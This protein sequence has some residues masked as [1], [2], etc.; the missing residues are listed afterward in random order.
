[1]NIYLFVYLW[2]LPRPWKGPVQVRGLEDSA[3]LALQK[4]RFPHILDGLV[5]P[6]AC[7]TQFY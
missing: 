7:D 4:V 2:P 6:Y 3:S 1:M 5:Y